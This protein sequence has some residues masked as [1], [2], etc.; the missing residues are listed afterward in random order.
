MRAVPY[1]KL[2]TDADSPGL[3]YN[4][5]LVHGRQM[6]SIQWG[7]NGLLKEFFN[8][9]GIKPLYPGGKS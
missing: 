7:K 1:K 5:G 4:R 2:L 6:P 3:V 9:F 8:G